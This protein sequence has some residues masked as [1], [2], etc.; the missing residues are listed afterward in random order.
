M[1]LA[2][3]AIVLGM[4]AAGASAAVVSSHSVNFASRQMVAAGAPMPTCG[5]NA[6]SGQGRLVMSAPMPTCGP[7]ACTGQGK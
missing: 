2:I 5:P 1:K 7:N 4:F 6:C 3:R